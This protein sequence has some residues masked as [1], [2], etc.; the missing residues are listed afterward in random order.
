M[1]TPF[2]RKVEETLFYKDLHNGSEFVFI[3]PELYFED[4]RKCGTVEGEFIN[5]LGAIDY[6]IFKDGE[7]RNYLKKMKPF[8]F[9]SMFYTKPGSMEKVKNLK[10]KGAQAQ[11]Y[12]ILHY[13]DN[14]SDEIVHSIF[15]VQNIDYAET[16][17][18]LFVKSGR[19]NTNIPYDEI[20]RYLTET[21]S[22]NGS[23]YAVN[24]QLLNLIISEICRDPEDI[25]KPFRLSSAI[26]KDMNAYI[27][28]SIKES[29]KYVSPYQ[30]I[31]SEVWDEGVI[32]SIMS[33]ERDGG[34][35]SP[36]EKIMTD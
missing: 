34:I 5:I 15:T 20:Y 3:V 32:G 14:G 13:R 7:E 4:G 9:P 35:T 10:L 18:A 2:I 23:G 17:N 22:I 28:I 30:S 25:S 6:A 29:P 33:S 16:I 1:N 36:L 19:V 27:P 21:I 12:R 8:F 11:D 31:T 26:K 24:Y